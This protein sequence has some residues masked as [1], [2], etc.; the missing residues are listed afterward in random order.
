MVAGGFLNSS[1]FVVGRFPPLIRF[2]SPLTSFS[3]CYG[4]F[5]PAQCLIWCCLT[6]KLLINVVEE[7]MYGVFGQAW[8]QLSYLVSDLDTGSESF[9]LP[10]SPLCILLGVVSRLTWLKALSVP[11]ASG[12]SVF[13]QLVSVISG[14]KLLGRSVYISWELLLLLFDKAYKTY[15][16]H[17]KKTHSF[18]QVKK[19]KSSSLTFE[20]F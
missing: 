16:F 18:E 10:L 1:S 13:L 5:A 11:L 19:N 4:S 17:V 9:L 15:F 7:W 8:W 2:L 20:F 3:R 14:N 6:L 12:I